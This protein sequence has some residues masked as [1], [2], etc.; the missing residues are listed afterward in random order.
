MCSSK[1]VILPVAAVSTLSV[2][3]FGS[4]CTPTPMGPPLGSGGSTTTNQSSEPSGNGGTGGVVGPSVT[5]T[6]PDLPPPSDNGGTGG[7]T[8]PATWPPEGFVVKEASYGA[9]ALG[10]LVSSLP[11]A[12]DGQLGSEGGP[13]RCSGLFGVLRDFKMGTVEGGH[14][15]FEKPPMVRDEGLVTDMLGDDKKPVYAHGDETTRTTSGQ[16]NFDQWYRD[17]PDVNTAYVIGFQFVPNGDVFTFAAS[18]G[19]TDADVEDTSYYPLDD[20][21]FGNEGK[22]HNYHFT[23]EIHTSFTY[24]GG[25]IFTFQGD[26]DVFVYINNHRVIDLGGIHEQLTQTVDLDAQ[27]EALEI[28][29]GNIYELAVFNAER[30]TTQSNFRIDTTMVFEDCGQIIK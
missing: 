14:P 7:T 20:Q 28:T 18:L 1:L 24:N 16:A 8:T 11:D 19:N 9:Y 27:A 21:G 13:G 25:E 15:D 2:V 26:D 29:T 17:V 30:H 10:P 6:L 4:A 23:T 12:T 5:V 22:R 3:L